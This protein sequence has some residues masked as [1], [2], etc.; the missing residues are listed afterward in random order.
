MQGYLPTT[1]KAMTLDWRRRGWRWG[2]EGHREGAKLTLWQKKTPKIAHLDTPLTTKTLLEYCFSSLLIT[3]Y[4][5]WFNYSQQKKKGG[6]GYN[7][8]TWAIFS[9]TPSST[10]FFF[11]TLLYVPLSLKT[12]ESP[13]LSIIMSRVPL[14]YPQALSGSLCPVCAPPFPG[15]HGEFPT[16]M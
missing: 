6:N 5:S 15:Y 11:P 14:S 16:P 8:S 9:E 7:S 10:P 13:P 1:E 3:S 4:R 12:M 2:R